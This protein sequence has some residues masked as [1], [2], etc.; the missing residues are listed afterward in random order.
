VV[1]TEFDTPIPEESRLAVND[2]KDCIAD[3][4]FNFRPEREKPYVLVFR[5]RHRRQ[6]RPPK[7]LLFGPPGKNMRKVFKETIVDEGGIRADL[8]M[9]HGKARLH[10]QYITD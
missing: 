1:E 4:R 5:V 2:R 7:V 6:Y 9:T 8:E 10:I 3:V